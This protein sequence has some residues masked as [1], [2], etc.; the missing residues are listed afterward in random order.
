MPGLHFPFCGSANKSPGRREEM[1]IGAIIGW[2]AGA[3]A[4]L[5][6]FIEVSKIKINPWSSLFRWVGKKMNAEV[7]DE[8]KELKKNDEEIRKEQEKLRKTAA[9]YLSAHELDC[10]TRFDVAEVYQSGSGALEHIEYIKNA[11]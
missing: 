10:P 5:S 7:M 11:F 4:L 9:F 1:S 3:L 6:T 2:V 8:I